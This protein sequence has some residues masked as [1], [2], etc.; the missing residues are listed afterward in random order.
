[1][2][3]WFREASDDEDEDDD[4]DE[5]RALTAREAF[6]HFLSDSHLQAK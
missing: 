4:E 1:M 5:E 6:R 3:S 2:T